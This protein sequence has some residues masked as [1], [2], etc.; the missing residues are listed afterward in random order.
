M[1]AVV[2]QKPVLIMNFDEKPDETD[3]VKNGIALGV[4]NRENLQATLIRLLQDDSEL[5][6]NRAKYINHYLYRIDGKASI[7][8]AEE[9]IRLLGGG[10]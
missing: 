6:V 1:T 4:Y 3:Y 5:A 2:A 10:E 9:M 7:R 8:I